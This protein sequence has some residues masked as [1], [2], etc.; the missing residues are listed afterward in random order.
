MPGISRM[1]LKNEPA[2]Y[3]VMSRTALDRFPIQK[4]EFMQKIKK[5][6]NKPIINLFFILLL[7]FIK[8]NT[9]F[10]YAA[11]AKSI[12]TVVELF[13]EIIIPDLRYAYTVEDEYELIFSLPLHISYSFDLFGDHLSVSTFVEFQYLPKPE[14]FDTVSGLRMSLFIEK[15]SGIFIEYGEM[16]LEYKNDQFTGIGITFS[17]FSGSLEFNHRNYYG[18]YFKYDFSVGMTYPIGID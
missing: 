11:L 5:N 8:P 6:I 3:H 7:F 18:E 9:A 12:D 10:G 15:N 17:C 2:V 14:K 16:L 1:V 13:I 4:K